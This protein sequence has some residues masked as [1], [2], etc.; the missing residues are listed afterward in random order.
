M[1]QSAPQPIWL[2]P[3]C[4]LLSIYTLK[5]TGHLEAIYNA[6]L[7]FVVF[8]LTFVGANMLL[9]ASIKLP[10]DPFTEELQE[11]LARVER[12][13]A[14]REDAAVS[15]HWNSSSEGKETEGEKPDKRQNNKDGK[16]LQKRLRAIAKPDKN[17]KL[18]ARRVSVSEVVFNQRGHK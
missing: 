16:L 7:V 8:A 14:W 10:A 11:Q 18:G 4:M 1:P 13:R 2:T 15:M 5:L 9:P 12:V 6:I 3:A 17:E